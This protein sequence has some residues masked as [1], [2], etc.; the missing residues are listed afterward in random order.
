MVDQAPGQNFGSTTQ[1]EGGSLLFSII[2][3]NKDMD[4]RQLA[5]SIVRNMMSAQIDVTYSF[6]RR[7]YSIAPSV[8]CFRYSSRAT[9][10]SISVSLPFSTA[11]AISF[12]AA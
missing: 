1:T 5:C 11:A 3:I 4:T 7:K 9:L 8:A 10:I 12:A 6:V 2:D